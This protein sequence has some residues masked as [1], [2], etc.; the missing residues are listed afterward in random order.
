[1]A[2]VFEDT[3]GAGGGTGAFPPD[4]ALEQEWRDA[5]AGA[6]I[7]PDAALERVVEGVLEALRACHR[8]APGPGI[9]RE[10]AE[11]VAALARTIARIAA[12]P[13]LTEARESAGAHELLAA[14][15]DELYVK[16]LPP[17]DL[18]SAELA[19]P[20]PSLLSGEREPTDGPVEGDGLLGS[21]LSALRAVPASA[22]QLAKSRGG[23]ACVRLLYSGIQNPGCRGEC[24]ELL[25]AWVGAVDEERMP[26]L[27]KDHYAKNKKRPREE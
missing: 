9:S 6:G 10:L 22:A 16:D 7:P 12:Q 14:C 23:E 17:I 1:M 27:Y 24:R 2:Q 21:I 18:D 8:R 26:K 20:L 19:Y 15:L 5:A 3:S 4:P 11:D 25:K 13:L